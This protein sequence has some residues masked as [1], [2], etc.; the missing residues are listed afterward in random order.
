MQCEKFESRLQ[1]LLDQRERP[2]YDALLLD[3]AESCEN[4]RETLMLQEQLFSGLDLWETPRM[5]DGFAQRVVEQH[6]SEVN[7][8][9]LPER[10]GG[11][12]PIAWKVFAGTVA[13]SLLVG[14]IVASAW[15]SANRAALPQPTVVETPAPQLPVAP[16]VKTPVQVVEQPLVSPE[17]TSPEHASPD[18]LAMQFVSSAPELFDGH[19]T[20]RMIREVTTSLPE[21]ATVE[22]NIPALRPITSSFS[23]TIGIVRKTLPGG[24]EAPNRA[25][26]KPEPTLKPQ[27]ELSRD[28]GQ[29]LV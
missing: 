21:V 12:G 13:A 7:Q 8:V 26:P 9:Q 20:G 15:Y 28:D 24:R 5:S 27:A 22:E 3:H 19:A 17:P 18:Y 10:G 4:C 23:Q 16:E 25:E 14:C 1:D 29:V 2:E 11:S 6:L